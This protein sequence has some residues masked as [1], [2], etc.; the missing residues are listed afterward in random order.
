MLSQCRSKKGKTVM[1]EKAIEEYLRNQVKALGG[2]AYKFVSPGNAGVPDRLVCLPGGKVVF[3]ELKAPGKKPT[4][5]QLK[6]HLE[7]LKLNQ[8]VYVVDSKLEVD[9]IIGI[10]KKV[11]SE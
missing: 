7:L 5:L 1:N 10:C 2:K 4:T 8:K 9:N 11:M 3:I 6:K